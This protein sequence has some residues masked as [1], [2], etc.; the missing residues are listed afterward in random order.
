MAPQKSSAA[1]TTSLL[2]LLFESIVYS[3]SMGD[4]N[5]IVRFFD[6]ETRRETHHYYLHHPD[7]DLT[8]P[9]LLPMKSVAYTVETAIKI[10]LAASYSDSEN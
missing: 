3:P 6:R 2:S 9:S 7:I 4:P 10:N 1:S 8:Q 5:C